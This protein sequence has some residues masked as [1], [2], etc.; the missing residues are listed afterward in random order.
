MNGGFL[1]HSSR[2]L[3]L[4]SGSLKIPRALVITLLERTHPSS[5][6]LL[7]HGGGLGSSQY[8]LPFHISRCF[9][10]LSPLPGTPS[11]VFT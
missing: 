9:T 7:L 11:P 8:I 4:D 10:L 5:M 1:G 6:T 3:M 2:L